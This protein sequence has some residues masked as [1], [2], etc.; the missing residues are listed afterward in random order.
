MSPLDKARELIL[1]LSTEADAAAEITQIESL[2]PDLQTQ[3]L[4]ELYN[5]AEQKAK[6]GDV[7]GISVLLRV[8]EH[9]KD[10]SHDRMLLHYIAEA[11]ANQA[12][13]GNSEDPAELKQALKIISQAFADADSINESTTG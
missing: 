6:D 11:Q 8:F 12:L 4:E 3:R 13:A 5:T 1:S 7:K 2:S 10:K 9:F